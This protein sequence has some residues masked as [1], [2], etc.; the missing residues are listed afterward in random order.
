MAAI[1][2]VEVKRYD[3]ENV[4]R[5]NLPSGSDSLVLMLDVF[6]GGYD[7]EWFS[8]ENLDRFVHKADKHTSEAVEALATFETGCKSTFRKRGSLQYL[9]SNY[10]K[11]YPDECSYL[12]LENTFY[13][14][15]WER[16]E[17]RNSIVLSVDAR[18]TEP[19][20]DFVDELCNRSTD[21]PIRV[22]LSQAKDV[23][24]EEV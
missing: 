7:V 20:Q 17:G 21:E 19:L 9:L 16:E 1:D 10:G 18:D 5:Y 8:D 11:F 6:E 4:K 13:S 22:A 2:P 3:E 12:R 15:G 23:I 14:I 24:H